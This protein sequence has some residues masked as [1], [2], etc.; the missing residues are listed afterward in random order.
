MSEAPGRGRRACVACALVGLFCLPLAGCSSVEGE[1]PNALEP[2]EIQSATE[3][4]SERRAE[5][6]PGDL[7]ARE[8]HVRGTFH[9][10]R[11]DGSSAD[12]RR[13]MDA[14]FSG[15]DA[16]DGQQWFWS[17]GP[18]SRLVFDLEKPLSIRLSFSGFPFL[19]RGAR[20]QRVHVWANLSFVESFSVVPGES[21]YSSLL[22][23][24]AVHAGRNE[25]FLRYDWTEVPA[26]VLPESPDQRELAFAYTRIELTPETSPASPVRV[27][28]GAS[29]EPAIV[30][31]REAELS[32][33]FWPPAKAHLELGWAVLSNGASLPAPVA[34]RVELEDDEGSR[35]LWEGLV[36][37]S[38]TID[39]ARFDLG[40]ER[41]R[42]V[43][44]RLGVG[45]LP[46]GARLA[47][48]A[49][50]VETAEPADRP[51]ASA[52]R[53]PQGTNVVVILLDAATRKY[54]GV[55]GGDPDA[56]PAVDALAAESLIFDSAF[57][58]GS[59]TLA[60]MG[61]LFTSR[62]PN[63]HGLLAE[64]DRVAPGLPTLAGSLADAGYAT[65]VF[66]G[67][68]YV[69]REYELARGFRDAFALFARDGSGRRGVARAD[70]FQEPVAR[71]IADK[72]DQPFFA[73]VHYVQPHEPYDA[74]SP[75]LYRLDSSYD[76]PITGSQEEMRRIFRGEVALHDDDVRYIRQLYAGNLRYADRAVGRLVDE[77]RRQGLLE[78]TVVVVTA[79]HGE[80]LGERGTFGHGHSVERE[81]IET[82]L[83]VRLPGAQ[84]RHGRR[85]LQVSGVDLMP[86]LLET[87]G[88]PPPS[89]LRGRNFLDPNAGL[90]PAWPRSIVS[91]A[92]G[93]VGRVAVIAGDLK[94][95]DEPNSGRRRLSQ[96]PEQEDGPN[97]RWERAV[98][99]AYLEGEADRLRVT[100]ETPR[101]RQEAPITPE[102]R[103]ALRALGYIED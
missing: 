76:G 7:L 50:R 102:T 10:V 72:R 83:I 18:S 34:A 11:I 6:D 97:L 2:I 94:Y 23:A 81:L 59:Y 55:Y 28:L 1:P 68:P 24:A 57:A 12:A 75:D 85:R 16:A 45:E 100:R 56:T 46:K 44:L 96:L 14:G 70:E 64:G 65:A 47:W 80:L 78:R 41:S 19:P 20:A 91:V 67:S 71:W 31:D 4:W 13:Y 99:F 15:P 88:V 30:I 25:V 62:L 53:L 39:R 74:G 82:P 52:P 37:G 92:G 26:R 9:P 79:D 63:E 5:A 27:M 98:T 86:T 35:V 93:R 32:W 48:I 90:T 38:E 87:L 42:A 8:V 49:P 58:N 101:F 66:A 61:S 84:N 21:T 17:D 33:L 95:D 73:F 43:R 77:L 40:L 3:A 60:S 54:F 22:P 103:N 89:G 51:A 36:Q 69:S 29:R